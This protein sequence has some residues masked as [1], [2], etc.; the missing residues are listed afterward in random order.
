MWLKNMVGKKSWNRLSEEASSDP[1]IQTMAKSEK[2]ESENGIHKKEMFLVIW[3]QWFV[4]T[5][6]KYVCKVVLNV[7]VSS[8]FDMNMYHDPLG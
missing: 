4:K 5:V 7:I 8:L 3:E 1:W 2:S 6:C